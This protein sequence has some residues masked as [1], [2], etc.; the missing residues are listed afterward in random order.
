[1]GDRLTRIYTR[2]GDD[3][4]TGLADGTRIAKTDA[5]IEAIGTVDELNA[6][7]GVMRAQSL[8]DDI[9]ALLERVQHRLFD[10]GGE[11]AVPG[12]QAIDAQHVAA[13]ETAL[14]RLNADLPALRDFILPGGNP[15]AAACHVCRTVCRRAERCLLS[16][17]QHTPLNAAS[18]HYLNRLSDLLFVMARVLAR[19]DG[20]SEVLWNKDL[21]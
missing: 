2:T 12:S 5:R 16:L 13:L 4:T 9:D 14:D 18:L 17:H 6:A 7:V 3:G 1:M 15:P 10:I 19:L 21:R 8:P 11:L 20:N